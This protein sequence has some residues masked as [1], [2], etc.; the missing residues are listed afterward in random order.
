MSYLQNRFPSFSELILTLTGFISA[1]FSLP[2]NVTH[3]SRVLAYIHFGVLAFS[4]FPSSTSLP[5]WMQGPT[6]YLKGSKSTWGVTALNSSVLQSEIV[7]GTKGNEFKPWDD[8]GED[9]TAETGH[10]LVSNQN[11]KTTVISGPVSS[12]TVIMLVLA[13][14]FLR[15]F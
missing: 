11:S 5:P 15:C 12:S 14:W 13:K 9:K 10:G 8:S 7:K 3:P 6:E 1:Y 2:Q 4:I